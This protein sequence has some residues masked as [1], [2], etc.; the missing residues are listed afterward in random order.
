M[1]VVGA[2]AVPATGRVRGGLRRPWLR[3][4][5]QPFGIGAFILVYVHR[6]ADWMWGLFFE[7]ARTGYS[8][9]RSPLEFEVLQIFPATG[10]LQLDK[11]I[12]PNHT[13]ISFSVYR[14]VSGEEV[15]IVSGNDLDTGTLEND[16]V[17]TMADVTLIQ[18]G[19][20][21]VITEFIARTE[22]LPLSTPVDFTTD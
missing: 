16:E 2:G 13:G 15:E 18:P 19:D 12:E 10:R 8:I 17:F 6:G 20:K 22:F 1:S 11:N 14:N 3:R 4:R 9:V 5:D 7:N 21:L